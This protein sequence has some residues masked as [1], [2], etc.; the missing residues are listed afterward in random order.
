[1][2]IVANI[3]PV[4]AP[5]PADL[6]RDL[7]A[8]LATLD[9]WQAK[10]WVRRAADQ[11]GLP[12]PASQCRPFAREAEQGWRAAI[13]RAEYAE[14]EN[15][16]LRAALDDLWHFYDNPGAGSLPKTVARRVC[17]ALGRPVP[18]HYQGDEWDG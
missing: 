2:S 18:E 6:S 11:A 7:A 4:P 17:E 16:R 5:T 9:A 14:V 1:M 10:Q 15:K 3:N 13:R 8:D 12:W